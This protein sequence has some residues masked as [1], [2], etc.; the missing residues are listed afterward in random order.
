MQV[1]ILIYIYY[2]MIESKRNRDPI[3]DKGMKAWSEQSQL[4][5]TAASSSEFMSQCIGH[6]RGRPSK[7]ECIFFRS[8]H[9]PF[10]YI[11]LHCT[12][13]MIH[14][15]YCNVLRYVHIYI[16]YVYIYMIMYKSIYTYSVCTLDIYIQSLGDDWLF[17]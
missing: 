11:T 13:Y 8:R 10:I 15:R 12:T 16:S 7:K 6:F 9:V 5:A 14:N 2:N 4:P 1:D 17:N 3:I